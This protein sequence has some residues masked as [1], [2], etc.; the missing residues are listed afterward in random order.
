MK[1]HLFGIL[2]ILAFACTVFA[3]TYTAISTITPGSRAR[4][5]TINDLNTNTAAAFALLPDEDDL[6]L[7]TQTAAS[8]T[9]AAD[10]YIVSLPTTPVA[11]V[12]NMLVVMLPSATNT[13]AS[14]IN[15]DSLGVVAIKD[16]AGSALSAGAIVIGIPVEMRYST[17]TG[18]FHLN[19]STGAAGAVLETDYDATTFLYATSDNTPQAKTPA[20]VR[21]ILNSTND[22]LT[23]K[24]DHASSTAATYNIAEAQHYGGSASNGDADVQEMD[25]DAAVAGMSIIIRDGAGGAITLDPN[26]T[27][28][29]VYEGTAAAAGEALISSGA[30]YDFITL[31]CFDTG[32]WEVLGHDTNGWS[33]ETP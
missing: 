1:K 33:E 4:S 14:T 3:S 8:D 23:G 30:K 21:V 2:L 31:V 15:V 29:F 12:D 32:V 26:G 5:S 6:S 24:I 11:Y 13:G 20:E 27:D 9:G 16:Q 28:Y 22:E 18:F 10:A 7:G 25:L 19:Q 17:V